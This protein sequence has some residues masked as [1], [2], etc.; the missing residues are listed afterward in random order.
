MNNLHKTKIIFQMN[1]I[2]MQEAYGELLEN[3]PIQITL[4][5]PML[6][7]LLPS[8]ITYPVRFKNIKK[9]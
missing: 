3:S 2:S 9:Q 8:E 7:F 1:G 5:I 6:I 4:I